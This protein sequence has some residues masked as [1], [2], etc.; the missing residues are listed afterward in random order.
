[1]HIEVGVH[2]DSEN[3]SR[4]VKW[5]NSRNY[6]SRPFCREWRFYDIAIQ[7][8]H[9]DKL[10]ADLKW[11]HKDQLVGGFKT[12]FVKKVL[13]FFIKRLGMEVIDLKKI[14]KTPEKWFTPID[15]NSDAR[16]THSAYLEVLGGFKDSFDK[17]GHEEI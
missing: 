10:L 1:M 13:N 3:H 17:K 11:Y 16:C 9:K 2:T 8:V 4:F 14:E 6:G 7:E 5:V 12:K 15:W